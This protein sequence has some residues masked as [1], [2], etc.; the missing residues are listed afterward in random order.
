[1]RQGLVSRQRGIIVVGVR[2]ILSIALE[3]SSKWDRES[4]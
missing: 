4:S 3:K 1:M 2:A